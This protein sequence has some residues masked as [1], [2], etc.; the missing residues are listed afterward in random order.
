MHRLQH[1]HPLE[2]IGGAGAARLGD[3]FQVLALVLVDR[4]ERLSAYMGR[5]AALLGREA[6]SGAH[7]IRKP[8]QVGIVGEDLAR[9][10]IQQH[11]LDDHAAP[12]QRVAG[13]VPTGEVQ[14]SAHPVGTVGIE[15]FAVPRAFELFDEVCDIAF[16]RLVVDVSVAAWRA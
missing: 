11:D 16:G 13:S 15:R 9:D 8:S 12:A 3:R 4:R 6:H 1:T 10:E 2:H 5:D 7:R 14:Q